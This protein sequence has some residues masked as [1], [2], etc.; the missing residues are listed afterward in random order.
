[1]SSYSTHK[2]KSLEGMRRIMRHSGTVRHDDDARD[3]K[4]PMD[5][6]ERARALS[7]VGANRSRQWCASRWRQEIGAEIGRS[8][9][10]IPFAD[11]RS[12]LDAVGVSAV[13]LPSELLDASQ[14]STA[15]MTPT[16]SAKAANRRAWTPAQERWLMDSYGHM[17]LSRLADAFEAR[18]GFK[19][20][21]DSLKTKAFA[22]RSR[23][24]TEGDEE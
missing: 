16:K 22:L 9:H 3:A 18:F 6:S 19:R 2:A 10:S 5:A 14:G 12:V 11:V 24:S 20:S 8:C 1:M 7:F 23:E 21:T 15:E 4:Q 17:R 13:K